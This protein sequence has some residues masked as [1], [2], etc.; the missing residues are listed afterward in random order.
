MN[1]ETLQQDAIQNNNR[2]WRNPTEIICYK[3]KGTVKLK[4]FNFNSEYMGKWKVIE[5][6]K[7][8][9]CREIL[10]SITRV[11]FLLSLHA[12]A[13]GGKKCI[14]FRETLEYEWWNKNWRSENFGLELRMKISTLK[15]GIAILRE[16]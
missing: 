9:S 16:S 3:W 8:A 15:C 2:Q 6:I 14:Y 13:F 11:L 1:R 12:V 7:M 5:S 4:Y 10:W